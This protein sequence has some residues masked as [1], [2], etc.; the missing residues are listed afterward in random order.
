MEKEELILRNKFLDL[1]RNAY[2]KNIV[3]YSMFLNLYEQTIF[4]TLKNELPN[5]KY[6]MFG[7]YSEA[8]RKIVCF[9]CDKIPEFDM[10]EFLKVSPSNKKFADDLT[11]R[12]FL[13][14][15]MNLGIER[16]MIGDICIVDNVAHIITF[17]SMSETIINELSTVKRTKV[18]LEVESADELKAVNRMEYKK[19]NIPS[20]RLDSII[21]SIY[22]ISRSK[23]NL[24]IDAG[25]V[26]INSRQ[27]F[28]HSFKIKDGDIITVRGLGR[29]RFLGI[30]ALSK[31]GRLFAET[32]IFK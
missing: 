30:S 11:H 4:E 6:I 15:L 10:L 32:E 23:V 13:G 2:F 20:E 22:N 24:Y 25:K 21:G 18:V 19:I 7:G 3:T 1:A 31:K 17:K 5:I 29:A 28:S 26:F 27:C 12:D 8:E 16:H 9:Y 14:A